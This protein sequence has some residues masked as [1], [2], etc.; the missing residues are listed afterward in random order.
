[1]FN[2][3][4]LCLVTGRQKGKY[5][6][7]ELRVQWEK[8]RVKKAEH[9]LARA[10]ARL[11]LAADPFLAKMGGKK[12]RKAMLAAA[13]DRTVDLAYVVEQ[14]RAFVMNIGGQA[15]MMMPPMEK[16]DRK[17]VHE[18]ALTFGLKSVSKGR[19]EGRY[20]TVTK[21]TR[22]GWGVDEAKV[23]HIL[24]R[25]NRWGGG[26]K[27]NGKTSMPRHKDGEEVGKV[28]LD[29]PFYPKFSKL[30]RGCS[31]A[32]P[33]IGQSNIGFRILQSM[34][35]SEGDQVGVSSGGLHVPLT[36]VIKNT[37]LGLGASVA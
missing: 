3:L 28:Q 35:W 9:K 8:D 21:T 33:R 4:Y 15:S 24:S 26:G 31:Q 7:P 11:K 37:K 16:A 10:Q 20:T 14:I 12:G 13:K 6:S 23:K 22:T 34:G 1:M 32:A 29:I 17:I 27:S 19:G 25:A 18:L 5:I 2:K 30:T 36:A